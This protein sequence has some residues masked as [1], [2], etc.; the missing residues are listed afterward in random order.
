MSCCFDE[1]FSLEKW[2]SKKNCWRLSLLLTLCHPYTDGYFNITHIIRS[3]IIVLF[4]WKVFAKYQSL[5]QRNT[6]RKKSFYFHF[7][8]PPS[9]LLGAAAAEMGCVCCSSD[10]IRSGPIRSELGPCLTNHRPSLGS[11]CGQQR[12]DECNAHAPAFRPWNPEVHPTEGP[13]PASYW[14]ALT[15]KQPLLNCPRWPLFLSMFSVIRCSTW[16]LVS[17]QIKKKLSSHFLYIFY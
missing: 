10:N 3:F 12:G 2:F 8:V 16:C 14:T 7:L 11:S 13:Q 4:I 6:Q 15:S 1:S 17:Y 9:G 5:W